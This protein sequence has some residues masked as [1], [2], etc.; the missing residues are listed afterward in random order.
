MRKENQKI[1]MPL[2]SL[3]TPGKATVEVVILSDPV[4]LSRQTNSVQFNL[5][6]LKEYL[7]KWEKNR[8]EDLKLMCK[9]GYAV[10]SKLNK[11]KSLL[12]KWLN[13]I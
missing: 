13:W 3:D 8:E 7:C 4:S 2:V 12:F 11:N 1:L 6:D 9:A 5:D 10:Q